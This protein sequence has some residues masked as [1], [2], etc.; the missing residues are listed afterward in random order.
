MRERMMHFLKIRPRYFEAIKKGLKTFE[1]RYNDRDYSVGDLLCLRV[2]SGK[3]FTDESVTVEVIYV[4]YEFE[5][6]M[7]NYVVLGFKKVNYE[8]NKKK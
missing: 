5:G 1:V 7:P 6:L 8:P 2:W 3:E 4:L